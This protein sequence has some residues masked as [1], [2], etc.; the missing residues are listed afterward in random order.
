MTKKANIPVN[1]VP[2]LHDV[3]YLFCCFLKFGVMCNHLA[4][5]NATILLNAMLQ[6]F[7]SIF[8]K[9]LALFTFIVPSQKYDMNISLRIPSS[10]LTSSRLILSRSTLKIPI[11]PPKKVIL[12]KSSSKKYIII[13]E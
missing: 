1:L 13:S 12:L 4:S 9:C 6:T 5:T 7:A 3:S 11:S 8:F 2:F 10:K